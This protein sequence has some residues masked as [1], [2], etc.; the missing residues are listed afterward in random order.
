[1]NLIQV[2]VPDNM[3][4]R[5]TSIGRLLLDLGKLTPEGAERVLRLQKE[6]GLRFGDAALSLGLVSSEDIR[7]VV[8]M[9]FDYPYLQAGQ[10]SYSRELVAAYQPFTPQVEALRALRT[11][12]VLRWFAEH[13]STI[14]ITGVQSGDGSSY[15]AANLAVVF[16]QLGEQTLLIDANLRQPRQHKIFNLKGQRGLSDIIV[17]RADNDAIVRI[18][19]FMGLSVLGAGTIPPNPQELLSRGA[20]T[21]LLNNAANEYDV[22][23]VDT[24]SADESVDYQAIVARTGGAML[25]ARKNYTKLA[26]LDELSKKIKDIG[27]QVV[28]AVLNEYD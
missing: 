2:P 15:I 18:E 21:E 19:S 13:G 28:G 7:Q 14:A 22:I 1:M 27:A 6:K 9:Q 11:Q 10:G 12:L 20:F 25:V 23:I 4:K 8:S 3:I 16:S 24:S 5:D 17:G 26:K